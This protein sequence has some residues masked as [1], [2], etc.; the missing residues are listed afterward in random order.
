MPRNKRESFT[1]KPDNKNQAIR[2]QPYLSKMRKDWKYG[3]KIELWTKFFQ[4]ELNGEMGE[5]GSSEIQER[6][7]E[8]TR[9]VGALRHVLESSSISRA[10]QIKVYKP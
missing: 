7:T 1:K 10:S 6:I 5:A 3:G 2:R 8:G 4:N 9:C